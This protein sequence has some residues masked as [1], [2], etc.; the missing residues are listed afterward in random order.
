MVMAQPI[1]T[2][3]ELLA[4][5]DRYGRVLRERFAT[6]MVCRLGCIGCCQ[7]HLSL[8]AIEAENL[9]LYISDLSANLKTY[10]R[11]Q[12]LAT[13]EREKMLAANPPPPSTEFPPPPESSVPC[14][15]LVDGACAVY[16]ARPV[17]CRTH[18]FPLLYLEEETSEA[19]LEV[20]PLNFTEAQETL[21][22]LMEEDV[23]HMHSI[24]ER[25]VRINLAFM[26]Q[27]QDDALSGAARTSI[28]TIILS[29]TEAT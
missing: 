22:N 20:C 18:G 26:A 5:I 15:A 6:E 14:P 8:F 2:Y 25:L 12:A 3:R 17:I 29:A 9:R 10:L 16:K 11:S 1:E 27:A 23:F 13:M 24:N 21:E 7:Q 4:D 19:L 28:A